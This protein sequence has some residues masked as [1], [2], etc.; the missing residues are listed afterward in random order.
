MIIIATSFI[1][2]ISAIITLISPCANANRDPIEGRYSFSLTTFHPS[3]T[4]PQL[5]HAI[6]AST[7]GPP[8][9]AIRGPFGIS[10]ASIQSLPSPLIRDDGTSRFARV[11]N[12][13]IVG[14]TG[15][16]ADGRV[17]IEAA[18]RIAV[19][20]SYTFQEEMPMN[21]LLEEMSLLFQEYT[22]KPGVRPFG[23]CL[24]VAGA[25]DGLFRID[26]SGTVTKLDNIWKDGEGIAFVGRGNEQQI[27][28]QVQTKMKSLDR[29]GEEQGTG[30]S[31]EHVSQ[32]L[33][34][35]LKDL[36]IGGDDKLCQ[37]IILA[38]LKNTASDLSYRVNRISVH[39]EIL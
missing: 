3:G 22:M 34:Q 14:H 35:V 26:P 28:E 1:L 25:N 36:V 32:I 19:E 2:A 33:I 27:I 9:I 5:S 6:Q 12:S 10:L 37:F 15:V 29:G 7:L 30:T 13:I 39:D 20:H 18:Q 16:N 4:L 31:V 11:T 24:L 17:V 38:S 21:I 23:C 8:I